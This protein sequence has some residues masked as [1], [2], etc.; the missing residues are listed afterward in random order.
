MASLIDSDAEDELLDDPVALSLQRPEMCAPD[1]PPSPPPGVAAD[2]HGET[3]FTS[4]RRAKRRPRS[5]SLFRENSPSAA[6]PHAQ[7]S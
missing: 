7:I 4:L 1:P 5:P 3:P 6:R 2:T